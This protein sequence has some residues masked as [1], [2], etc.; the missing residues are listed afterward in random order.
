MSDLHIF[1]ETG[2]IG[3]TVL[4]L[5]RSYAGM[6]AFGHDKT[7]VHTSKTFRF[8]DPPMEIPNSP[9]VLE[10]YRNC[11][12]VKDI[13]EEVDYAN[14]E[15]MRF[16]QKYKV[17]ILQPMYC[18][19]D[20]DV[21]DWIDLKKYLPETNDNHEKIAVFQPVSLKHK[22]KKYLN[23]Y[24]SVWDRCINLLHEKNYHIYMIGAPDDPYELTLKKENLNKV[25]SKIGQWS[26]LQALAFLLY[27][28]DLVVSC[29]SWAGVWGAAAKIPSVNAWGYR[30]EMDIDLWVM[31]F[32]GNADYYKYYW[33]SQKDYCDATLAAHLS[34]ILRTRKMSQNG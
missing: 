31:R 26:I 25:I 21:R 27:K 34:N 15:T 16:S 32:L 8:S 22:P 28:S 2:A 14:P 29:D 11:H 20:H 6:K 24:I 7:V 4:N 9:D 17:P 13:V 5:C 1:C 30:Y 23:W 19:T 33:S 3:D 18:S 10:I 12:F